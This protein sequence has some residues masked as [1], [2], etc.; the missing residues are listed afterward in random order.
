MFGFIHLKRGFLLKKEKA[1]KN[2]SINMFCFYRFL[3]IRNLQYHS[4]YSAKIKLKKPAEM[5]ERG[6]QIRDLKARMCERWLW[7]AVSSAPDSGKQVAHSMS[8]KEES[9]FR[10]WNAPSDNI[11]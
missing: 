7:R 4:K 9:S 6:C 8:W 3:V 1:N 11:E 2:Y 5:V 10:F